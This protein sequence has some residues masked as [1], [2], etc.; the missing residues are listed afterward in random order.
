MVVLACL[1]LG[2]GA[3][4]AVGLAG[5]P[6]TDGPD[7]GRA[8]SAA[9]ARRLAAM[10]V[11]NYRD[12]RAGLRA[13]LGPPEGPTRLTGWVDWNRALIY[14]SVT[15]PGTAVAHGLIQ[16]VPGLIASRPDP[17]ARTDAGDPGPL[18]AGPGAA[19]TGPRMA[20]PPGPGPSPP[21]PRSNHRP[22]GGGSAGRTPAG[23][24]RNRSTRWS[25]CCSGSPPTGR[26]RST[27]WPTGR[28]AGS[29]ATG[30]RAPPSTYCG[31]PPPG[32]RP[33]ARPV[34]RRS[35]RW[36]ARSGTGWTTTP[37][38]TGWPPSCPADCRSPSTWTARPGPN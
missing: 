5:R 30:R 12:G 28:P 26:T 24:G 18:P 36:A 25:P 6:T 22:T 16:A 15:G 20:R 1:A 8:L 27:A 35:R 38:C 32:R 7:E 14:L 9:E 31:V 11:T 17:T 13:T 3:G 33:V 23:P 29:A 2:S 10:R 34:R 4:L 37:G 19:P 21:Y